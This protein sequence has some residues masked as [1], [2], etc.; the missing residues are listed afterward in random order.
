MDIGRR[1]LLQFSAA[2]AMT[3]A[4]SACGGDGPQVS[5]DTSLPVGEFGA[6]STAEDVSLGLKL[7]G[8]KVLVTGCNSG[9]GYETMRVLALRG[10]MLSALA[11][12]W[13]KRSNR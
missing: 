4:L 2:T 6:E 3:S 1:Q 10:R 12:P 9:L 11:E 5:I 7:K 8:L 13:K